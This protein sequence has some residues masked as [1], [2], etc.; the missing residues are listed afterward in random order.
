MTEFDIITIG[1]A[2]QDVFLIGKAFR[3]VELDNIEYNLL[4]TGSKIDVEDIIYDT[5]G[6][7]TNA[8]LTF[9]RAGLRTCAI[10]KVGLDGPGREILHVLSKEHINTEH[11]IKNPKHHTGFTAMLVAPS[12]ESTMLVHRGASYSFEKREFKLSDIKT[13][14]L[15]ISSLAGNLAVLNH[16]IKWANK[17]RVSVAVNPGALELLKPVRL[18]HILISADVV[19]INREEIAQLTSKADTFDA[20]LAAREA[21]LHTVV[22]T[23]GPAGAWVL[24]GSYVYFSG[25]Y[26]KS[27]V[28][29]RTGAGDAYG[30]GFVAALIKHQTIERAMTYG[31]ANATSVIGYVGAKAGIIRDPV[32]KKVKIKKTVLGEI[33]ETEN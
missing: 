24:D 20:L 12:G 7:A 9:A 4:Q 15:Y 27:K 13:R 18:R 22:L 26:K 19:I 33:Y 14:W 31:A 10:A 29:D 25:M 5:G 3:T 11:M 30:S 6:G 1:A 21:G 8:A 32:L 16:L 28:V 17:N 23:D 2:T